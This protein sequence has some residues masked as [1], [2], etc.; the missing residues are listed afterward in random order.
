[1]FTI[2]EFL[3][4]EVKPA[5][6]CTE[7]GAVALAVARA[8]EELQDRS[9][10]DSITV[11][12]SDSIY[13]NGMAVGIPGAYGAKGNA[14]AA[15]LAALCGKSSFGLEALKDCRPEL[16]P[17]AEAMVSKGQVRIMRCADLEGLLIDATVQS[18]IEEACCVIIGGHTNIVKVEYCGKVLFESDN[19]HRNAS[20]TAATNNSAATD[21]TAAAGASPD[22]IYQQMIGSYFMDILSLADKIDEEDI[23]H[24]LSGVTMNRK[25]ADYGV[26]DAFTGG[27]GFGKKL[28][29]LIARGIVA[30]DVIN[31]AKYLC[32]AAADAR[33]AGAA[34][35]IMSSAGSGNHGIVAILPVAI[36]AEQAGKST[37]AMA[38]ALATSHVVTGFVKSKLGRLSPVCGCTVAAG[39]GAAAGL[40][41][42][43]GGTNTQIELAVKTVLSSL[44]GMVCDGAKGSCSL[45]VGNAAGEAFMASYFA[46]E[47]LGI[48]TSQGIIDACIE[49]TTDNVGVLNREGM[50]MVDK[51]LIGIMEQ[52]SPA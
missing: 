31:Q 27:I 28:K 9:A 30:D 15:A 51:V 5:L 48:S 22:A 32:Y 6:G 12:V 20:A 19:V 35:P 25:M 24:L 26:S 3:R 17:P 39:S 13:K 52:R 38:V 40:V 11:K 42:L 8:C 1:M 4:S 29:D 2:K 46:L 34:Y 10:I 37:R 50:G 14:V 45:K 18:K 47:G 23:V 43:F 49:K 36:A 7:P 21:N 33:M 16:V 44:A 41:R